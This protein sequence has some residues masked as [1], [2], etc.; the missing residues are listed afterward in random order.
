MKLYADLLKARL[1]ANITTASTSITLDDAS[2]LPT[3]GGGEYFIVEIKQGAT[4]ERVV[5]TAV[6]GDVLTV[7][8]ATYYP[9]AFKAGALCTVSIDPDGYTLATG[10]GISDGDKG[11]ITVAS[12][13][14]AWTIDNGAVTLAKQADMATA[15]VVYR[16]TAG[17]GAPE[18]NSLATLKTDLGLTGTNSGDQTS[19]VGIIGT[20]AQ[21]DTAC[22]DGNFLYSGDVTQ[23]TDE[24]AQDAVGAMVDSSLTYVDGTP[25]L[26]RAALTGDVTASAG[27]NAT[28]IANDA[29]TYAKM[30]NV[31]ATDKLL[32]RSTAGS[33]DVEEIT[34]TSF[35][36]SVLDDADAATARTTLGLAIGTNVQAYDAELA[37]IAGL[38]SAANKLPYFTGSGTAALADISSAMRTFLTT[39]SSANFLSLLTDSIGVGEVAFGEQGTWTPVFTFTTP[40]NLS[41]SYATQLGYYA[42][43]GDFVILYC[44]LVC[45]PTHTTASGSARVTGAPYGQINVTNSGGGSILHHSSALTYPAGCTWVNV[46]ILSASST[47]DIVGAGSA[48]TVTNLTTTQYPTAT[49]Q[50][51]RF[52][53]TYI[54]S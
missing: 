10:G 28:T 25:L 50:T 23:Y 13:G 36:R 11:D 18:V 26:Q 30:Q 32:G 31:S 6:V 42:R 37:A 34:C 7:T 47:M 12:S 52:F 33:G 48:T 39:S 4:V 20:K 45:T 51:I 27:S 29:V 22:T 17:T 15:S 54:T 1:A 16:K 46:R 44:N 2:S 21:F 19:I 49:A 38:T 43:V 41:V 9:H 53:A 40:G 24:M 3:L 5:C 35:A 8:R 14:T